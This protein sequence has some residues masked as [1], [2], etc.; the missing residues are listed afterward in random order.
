M[1]RE[2]RCGLSCLFFELLTF[3]L[4]SWVDVKNRGRKSEVPT[5]WGE[6]QLL[7]TSRVGNSCARKTHSEEGVY[8]ILFKARVTFW[9][10]MHKWLWC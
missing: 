7:Q 5:L 9:I 4:S 6:T 8:E 3:L 1:K 2:R 10:K